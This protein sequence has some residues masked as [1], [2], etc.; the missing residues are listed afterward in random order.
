[1]RIDPKPSPG[2]KMRAYLKLLRI[3]GFAALGVVLVFAV[4]G[5]FKAGVSG[6]INGLT[7]GLIAGAVGFPFL[8][9]IISLMY[10][11]EFAGRWGEAS[12]HK[13][14]EGK[15]EDENHQS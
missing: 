5:L 2:S 9:V 1:M 13:G 4:V 11:S 6:L 15:P 14:M 12:D 8:G 3:Y 10:W 7:I